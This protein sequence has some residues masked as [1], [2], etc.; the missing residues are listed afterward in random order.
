ML[1]RWPDPTASYLRRRLVK[2]TAGRGAI[3]PT[4]RQRTI[5]GPDRRPGDQAPDLHSLGSGG[6]I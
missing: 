3:P 4:S 1:A 5:K 2:V 6:G